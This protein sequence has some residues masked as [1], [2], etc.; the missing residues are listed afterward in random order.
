[1]L[2]VITR[3]RYVLVGLV[4]IPTTSESLVRDL[5]TEFPGARSN[6]PQLLSSPSARIL[7]AFKVDEPFN[8]FLKSAPVRVAARYPGTKITQF[9]A[10][11][12]TLLAMEIY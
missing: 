1:V 9:P 2:K 10:L 12:I 8:I 7:L 11:V 5:T 4:Y 3:Q 6:T